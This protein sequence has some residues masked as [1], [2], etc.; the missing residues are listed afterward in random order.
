MIFK[1]KSYLKTSLK[2]MMFYKGDSPYD[3]VGK[4]EESETKLSNGE[5]IV[6]FFEYVP[7]TLRDLG[8]IKEIISNKS[9]ERVFGVKFNPGYL[10]SEEHNI[11]FPADVN[12]ILDTTSTELKEY[13]K[14]LKKAGLLD[15]YVSK[16]N[17]AY[18]KADLSKEETKGRTL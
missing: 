2:D 13:L 8:V 14:H 10:S 7:K 17:S 5:D 15:E 18:Q 1:K 6:M 3:V 4:L 12:Q 11:V 9:Y 16:L